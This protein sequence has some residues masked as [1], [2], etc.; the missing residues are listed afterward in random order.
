MRQ[1][2]P[3]TS[4][5]TNQ[6]PILTYYQTMLSIVPK[7]LKQGVNILK[8]SNSLLSSSASTICTPTTQLIALS[9]HSMSM[10][11]LLMGPYG[12]RQVLKYCTG[13]IPT[14]LKKDLP[15]H[16]TKILVL[17]SLR[18]CKSMRNVFLLHY[19]DK[20]VT[21]IGYGDIPKCHILTCLFHLKLYSFLTPCL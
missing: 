21:S 1:M 7:M 8:S 10:L 16:S 20:H 18:M 14:H 12:M 9:Q 17:T 19:V 2:N 3:H 15:H 6:L 13:Y 11:G 4:H 5:Q